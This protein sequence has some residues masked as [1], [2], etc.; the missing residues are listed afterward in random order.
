MTNQ[1]RMIKMFNENRGII[2]SLSHSN[3][4]IRTSESLRL[5]RIRS[6]RQS[7]EFPHF[8]VINI[9]VINQLHAAVHVLLDLISPNRIH[10][11]LHSQVSHVDRILR[12]CAASISFLFSPSNSSIGVAS[13]PTN[14]TF[15]ANPFCSSTC[16]IPSVTDSLGQKIPSACCEADQADIS[17]FL[18]SFGFVAPA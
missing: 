13:N 1:I 7:Q 14:F 6:R 8:R 2:W 15:P 5:W 4:A 18:L 10:T 11:R 16:S 17:A 12:D 9:L 3:F